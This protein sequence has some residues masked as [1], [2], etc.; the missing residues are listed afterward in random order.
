MHLSPTTHIA[1]H[2]TNS[3][4]PNS[5]NTHFA[6]VVTF[7]WLARI[8]G[9]AMNLVTLPLFI[10][11][12]DATDF[13]I[14]VVIVSLTSWFSLIDL[15]IGSSSQNSLSSKLARNQ[16]PKFLIGVC[17]VCGYAFPIGAIALLY[18]FV[19]SATH[20]LL[21]NLTTSAGAYEKTV[22]LAIILFAFLG[23]S[24]YVNRLLYGL[25][26]TSAVFKCQAIANLCATG[27]ASVCTFYLA[28][29][30]HVALLSIY[31]PVIILSASCLIHLHIKYGVVW[32]RRMLRAVLALAKKGFS[33]WFIFLFG[34]V[35]F[36]ID[37]LILAQFADPI[38][39]GT[40]G[41]VQKC[42]ALVLAFYGVILAASWPKWN[43]MFASKDFAALRE[44]LTQTLR[45][46][47]LG[48]TLLASL[49]LPWIDFGWQLL[50]GSML[51]PPSMGTICLLFIYLLLRIW[52]DTHTTMI[53][54]LGSIRWLMMWV[55]LQ[56]GLTFSLQL[57]AA[58]KYGVNGVIF[59]MIVGLLCTAVWLLPLQLRNEIGCKRNAN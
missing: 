24:G 9:L 18:F 13:S 4:E 43:S 41:V 38:A 1:C 7:G 42:V 39:V 6:R 52:T 19:P 16:D 54:A 5:V 3:S 55:P 53:F 50:A 17:V 57:F 49:A 48:A 45:K 56:L 34:A 27:L 25:G 21:N 10:R 58:A 35:L 26:R 12:L 29:S 33:F 51:A 8:S 23:N 44:S 47:L 28:P 22:L 2:V 11:W 30:I 32:G 15:G 31:T 59:A 46:A 37:I 36:S 20:L 14:Y 40:Y